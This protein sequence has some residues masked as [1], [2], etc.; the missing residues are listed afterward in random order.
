[1]TIELREL[2][3]TDLSSKY[4]RD[5]GNNNVRIEEEAEKD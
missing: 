4:A 5:M 1:M 2:A 3:I